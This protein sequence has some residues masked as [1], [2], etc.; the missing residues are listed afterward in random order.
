MA[1]LIVAIRPGLA[2]LLSQRS[3]RASAKV[4]PNASV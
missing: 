3:S 1:L 4:G 2:A